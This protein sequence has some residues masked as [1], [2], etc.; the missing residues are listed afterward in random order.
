MS[1]LDV[2]G[3]KWEELAK[4]PKVIH[5]GHNCNHLPTDERIG[6]AMV[7]TITRNQ[8]RD[9]PPPYGIEELRRLIADDLGTPNASVLI[10]NGSTEAIYQVL[11]VLLRPGDEMI[12]TDPAWPHIRNF[13][14]SLGSRV[15]EVPVYSQ[16]ASYRLT[17]AALLEQI[18]DRTKVIAIIDPLNPLG[19]RYSRDEVERICQI[20]AQRGIYVLHDATYR[21]FAWHEHWPALRSYERA[22]VTISLSKSCGFAGLRLGAAI[23]TEAMFETVA[24][25]QISRLGVSVVVQQ[26][27]IAAYKTKS[28]WLPRVL[29]TNKR[30]QKALAACFGATEGIK[31]L[32]YPSFGNFVAADITGT[33]RDAE[34]IVKRVLDAGYVIRSGAYTSPAFGD[35]FIRVTTTISESHIDSFCSTFPHIVSGMKELKTSPV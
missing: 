27:A 14:A 15:I 18:S 5:M 9:Y 16:A 2:G 30:N 8:Y 17:E 20:A 23:M 19:S 26:G 31:T 11:S 22:I 6:E 32:V 33:G 21:D 28:K 34:A 12:V 4:D 35:R 7:A 25:H 24:A 1:F 13:A 3:R 10:T 29:E